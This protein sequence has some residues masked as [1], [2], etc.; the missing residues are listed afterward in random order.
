MSK[1]KAP[2]SLTGLG[3]PP[4]FPPS[5]CSLRGGEGGKRMK[6]VTPSITDFGSIV[7]HTFQT[8]GGVKGCQT[9]CHIDS[10]NEQS[11]LAGS[12]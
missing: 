10:F 7:D 3:T 5:G 11:A 6:Y 4:M 12:A 1:D 8:P 9:G 2:F